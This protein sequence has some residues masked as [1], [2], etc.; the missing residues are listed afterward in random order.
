M[1]IV[2]A[3]TT[4]LVIGLVL[5]AAAAA[6]APQNTTPPSISGT[7]RAGSTLTASDG[8][9][10]NSP[11]SFTYQ[12][13][14]CASDG[15]A[16]GDITGAVSKTYTLATGDV[17]RT[18]RV[19]VTAVNTDGNT[20]ADSAAT[21]VVASKNGPTNTV[22]PTVSGSAVVGGTLT[23]SNGTW[24]PA[25]TS[26]TRQWQRCASDGTA[27]VNISGATGQTYGVRSEDVGHR[28]RAHI[29]AHTA[30]DQATVA[31]STSDVVTQTTQTT[32]TVVTTPA[33]KV[34]TVK[35]LSLRHVGTKIYARFRVC[36]QSPG[37]VAITERDQ[38]ARALPYTRHLAVQVGVCGTFA[39]HW[40]LLP[41]YRHPGR[42]L[43]T[44][45]A[46]SHGLLSKLASRSI[47]I[48]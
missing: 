34:P 45:R 9:W 15:T 26:F 25:P 16:C 42:L 7:D 44:M 31:S 43:V 47:I 36:A 10:S 28:L 30:T 12:W 35:I 21:D 29:T 5:A 1:R 17:G 6:A 20:T 46:S 40:L 8:T 39:K 33:P 38:K 48:H 4:A 19:A 37:R 22:K 18:V 27:C 23:V 2:L 32:T 13:Q 14:R 11:A 3:T 41:R 24:T